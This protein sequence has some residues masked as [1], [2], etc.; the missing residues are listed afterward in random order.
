MKN[1]VKQEIMLDCAGK[2]HVIMNISVI[3]IIG[4]TT[5]SI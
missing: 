4:T 1:V 2:Q 5:R 3:D